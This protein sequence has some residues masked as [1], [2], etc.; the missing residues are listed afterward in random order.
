M[1]DYT[2]LSKDEEGQ[3]RL[4]HVEFRGADDCV[5][6]QKYEGSCEVCGE[7]WPCTVTRLLNEI[8]AISKA[9]S[10]LWEL[11]REAYELF[12]PDTNSLDDPP[13]LQDPSLAGISD[14]D[15]WSWRVRGAFSLRSQFE[16]EAPNGNQG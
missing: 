2:P 12:S 1:V 7:K 9:Q 3:L 16:Q 13:D 6:C 5:E 15:A 4:E 11:L 10:S 8:D 14:A